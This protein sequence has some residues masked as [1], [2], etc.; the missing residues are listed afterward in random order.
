MPAPETELLLTRTS[1]PIQVSPEPV[2]NLLHTLL[3]LA[4]G[5]KISGLNDWV[6]KT[7]ATMSESERERNRLV[8]IGFYYAVMPTQS[9][10]GFL[11]Y[12]D[13]LAT[14]APAELRDKLMDAYSNLPC[15]ADVMHETDRDMALTD[16]ES[17][18]TFLNERFGPKHVDPEL[19][20]QAYA[21]VIDPPSM[22]ELIVSHLRHM[23]DRYLEAEWRR[24]EPM[25]LDAVQAFQQLDY[26]QMNMLEAAESVT[27]QS[28][29][30]KH[31]DN[32]LSQAEQLIFV[33]S[34]HVG[35]YVSAFQAGVIVRIIFGARLPEGVQMVA[36]DLSRAEILVRLGAL[37]DDTRLRILKLVADEGEKRSQDIIQQLELSQSA[38]SRHLTQLSATGYLKERR[39]EG[40]KCYQLN[41]A[42]LED[43]LR[44][45]SA[46][47]LAH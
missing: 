4:K 11:D 21:Y 10:A 38:A 37:A 25:V 41:P 35:P 46:F 3:L 8:M 24:V 36:P 14:M 9:W 42:R 23:W 27:G 32:M 15:Q 31:W 29:G 28:L 12:V 5:D 2:F 1:T 20:T 16:V 40:A 18:L 39:C 6:T 19:E 26:G 22:Q 30:D 47:L 17:Y 7:A 43:T 34:A 44:A 45:V 13:R 33:P